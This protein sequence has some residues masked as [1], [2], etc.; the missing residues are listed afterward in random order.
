LD[1]ETEWF[2]VW[3]LWSLE[4][5]DALNEAWTLVPGSLWR[6]FHDVITSPTREWDKVEFVPILET[7]G[8][9]GLLHFSLD[10]VVTSFGI[11]DLWI[12]H[13]VDGDY[14]GLYTKGVG[15]SGVFTSLAF[16]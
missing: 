1:W 12:V 7:D 11:V 2:V 9:E 16:A 8:F 3:T 10:F 6:G 5:V 4:A 13:L 14:H 15:K